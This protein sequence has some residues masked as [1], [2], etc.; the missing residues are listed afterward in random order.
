MTNN[1]ELIERARRC[2]PHWFPKWAKELLSQAADALEAAEREIERQKGLVRRVQASVKVIDATR[3]E[4]YDHYAK[5]SALN[6]E[7][8]AT[9]DSERAANAILTDELA[10]ERAKLAIAVEM[11]GVI[12]TTVED[13][14]YTVSA[15]HGPCAHTGAL[16]DIHAYATTALAEIRAGERH[17]G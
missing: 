7:A 9:L 10:S 12:L 4:I 3:T 14:A 8:I 16:N 1:R 2:D 5:N 11:L 17:G 15:E 6:H 13:E